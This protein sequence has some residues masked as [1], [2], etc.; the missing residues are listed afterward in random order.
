MIPETLKDIITKAMFQACRELDTGALRY[1]INPWT[2]CT[3]Q[4]QTCVTLNIY[5]DNPVKIVD[6][7]KKE[8]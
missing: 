3:G 5:M 2:T 1:S 4:E 8:E 6:E 7:K